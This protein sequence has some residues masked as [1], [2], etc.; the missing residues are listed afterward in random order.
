V[1]L[2]NIYTPISTFNARKAGECLSTAQ[3]GMRY[4]VLL[5]PGQE[6]FWFLMGAGREQQ[7]EGILAHVFSRFIQSVFETSC[8]IVASFSQGM[9]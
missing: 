8:Y 4:E 3:R 7:R 2:Y 6:E 1:Y 5:D 9:Y